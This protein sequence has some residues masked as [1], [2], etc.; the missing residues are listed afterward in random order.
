[1]AAQPAAQVKHGVTVATSVS[2]TLH[3][4]ARTSGSDRSSLLHAALSPASHLQ[5][6][7]AQSQSQERHLEWTA[8]RYLASKDPGSHAIGLAFLRRT[9]ALC[10]VCFG[11]TCCMTGGLL[12]LWG[13]GIERLV[14]VDICTHYTHWSCT[15]W[16]VD[17]VLVLVIIPIK[18]CYGMM[19]GWTAPMLILLA[20]FQSANLALLGCFSRSFAPIASQTFITFWVALVTIWAACIWQE[21]KLRAHL[22]EIAVAEKLARAGVDAGT[23]R[24][25]SCCCDWAAS[26]GHRSDCRDG[27]AFLAL[28]GSVSVLLCNFFLMLLKLCVDNEINDGWVRAALVLLVLSRTSAQRVCVFTCDRMMALVQMQLEMLTSGPTTRTRMQKPTPCSHVKATSD[29]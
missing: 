16:A 7:S 20:I 3:R 1:M 6:N 26:S 18:F 27:W 24:G 15:Q 17:G 11:L 13:N 5:A 19:H 28:Y 2:R 8:G 25:A 10:V 21:R 12:M 23:A 14:F 22:L 9:F 4:R 29:Y